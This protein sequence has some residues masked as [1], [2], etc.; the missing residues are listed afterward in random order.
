MDLR[1]NARL[2]YEGYV[3]V[4]GVYVSAREGQQSPGSR[5]RVLL[6]V[7]HQ[8]VGDPWRAVLLDHEDVPR[9]GWPLQREKVAGWRSYR[10][11]G[12]FL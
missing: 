9:R 5:C 3:L 6:C 2:E 12:G 7:F 11:S 8:G 4:V 10:V 1:S